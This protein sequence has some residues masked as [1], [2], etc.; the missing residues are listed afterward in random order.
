MNLKNESINKILI[1][2][3]REYI[4]IVR[5]KSFWLSTIIVP[6]LI[7]F[8]SFISG[9]SSIEAEKMFQYDLNEVG[10]IVIIDQANVISDVML[11]EKIS[12][13]S[14]D[15]QN[16]YI[17]QV[18]EKKIDA[19]ILYEQDIVNKG[20]IKI[21]SSDNGIFSRSKFNSVAEAI[22]KG[23]IISEIGNS[24]KV[25]LLQR[26]YNYSVLAYDENGELTDTVLTDLILPGFFIVIY[27]VLMAFALSYLLTG[28]SEE[29]EN[30]MIEI[31]MTI[32][33]PRDLV[34]GKIVSQVLIAFTQLFVLSGLSI[35]VLSVSTS[36]IDI[37][38]DAIS[39]SVKDI[40]I[41]SMYTVLGFSF[42]SSVTVAV[43]VIM[44]TQKEAQSFF[45]FFMFLTILPIYFISII[46]A[47][48][49]GSIATI[50]GLIPLLS[51]MVMIIRNALN[52][53]PLWQNVLS[54]V[55][56]LL[57]NYLSYEFASVL[58]KVG[59]LQ[60]GGKIDILKSL[61]KFKK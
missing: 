53:V 26:S 22:L 40:F 37:P 2:I 1:I 57:F 49:S 54:I 58:F 21:W 44:P 20:E 52:A 17:E 46:I 11:S 48:P 12:K 27:F 59:A 10:H 16:E 30:R 29:K 38:W 32:V 14:I 51:S 24:E 5:K 33:R 7:G 55:L 41:Y 8:I 39:I 45:G 23:S 4:K 25:S 56:L 42:L 31:I 18:K 34:I 19:L 3:K 61:K 43:G 28:I 35:A 50:T 13:V 36:K 60:Y 47:D 9:Y 15:E 6:I